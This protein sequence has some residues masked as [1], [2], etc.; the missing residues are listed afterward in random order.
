MCWW[1]RT[2]SKTFANNVT[3]GCRSRHFPPERTQVEKGH[4]RIEHRA[5]RSLP[6]EAGE[7]SF[8]FVAQIAR[9]DR[10]RE[11]AGGKTTEETVFIVTSLSAEQAGEARLA[12]LVR[13]H[14]AIENQLHY[15]RD[16]SFDEDRCRIRRPNGAQVMAAL[17]NLAISWSVNRH[18]LAPRRRAQTLPQI[19]RHVA[20]SLRAAIAA[21]TTNWK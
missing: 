3:T 4:G 14:W 1:S 10:K 15:R 7:I 17:R 6:V 5:L 21:V 2:T 18:D 13:G 12:A 9:V 16:W 20:K 19:Q 8:P 11:L